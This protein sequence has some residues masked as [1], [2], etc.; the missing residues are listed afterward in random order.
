MAGHDTTLIELFFTT[1]SA[2]HSETARPDST[3][4]SPVPV[5]AIQKPPLAQDTAVAGV[6]VS[7]T[8]DQRVNLGE[9]AVAAK[10]RPDESITAQPYP[11]EQA[12]ADS[13]RLST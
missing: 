6:V 5:P 8:T 2:D 3:S 1:R 7:A 10:I 4:T 11:T 12:A 13:G 9:E